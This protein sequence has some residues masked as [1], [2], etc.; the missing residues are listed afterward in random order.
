MVLAL[1]GPLDSWNK[2]A[3]PKILNSRAGIPADRFHATTEPCVVAKGR[4]PKAHELKAIEGGLAAK[5]SAIHKSVDKAMTTYVEDLA[6]KRKRLGEQQR[7]G[8]KRVQAP[9]N[10]DSVAAKEYRRVMRELLKRDQ[11]SV[12][13][14]AVLAD[15]AQ[16]YSLGLKAAEK[17]AELGEVIETP[18]GYLK[19]N[20]WQAI[21][22][23]CFEQRR[24]IE[25][26]LGLTPLSQVRLQGAK[27][28]DDDKPDKKEPANPWD[29][30]GA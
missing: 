15:Y 22:D 12:L 13:F 3:Q 7:P 30:L 5:R 2:S 19:Q 11:F 16:A 23:K 25:T 14:Q 10:L 1:A 24:K 21:A 26:E 18:S 17:V 6:A 4:I 28:G 27:L 8:G 9:S 20:P 29:K